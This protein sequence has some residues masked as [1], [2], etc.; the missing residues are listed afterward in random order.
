MR[1]FSFIR[2]CRY[3]ILADMPIMVIADMSILPIFS[4]ERISIVALK[5]FADMPI[6]K[7]SAVIADV[8]I[9]IGTPYSFTIAI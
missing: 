9:N 8:N 2:A 5:M 7:K 1:A 4:Y 6:L 3:N